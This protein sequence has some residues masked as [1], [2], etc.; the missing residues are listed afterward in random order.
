MSTLIP[1]RA[2]NII[3]AIDHMLSKAVARVTVHVINCV[4]I[5]Y[6]SKSIN[7]LQAVSCFYQ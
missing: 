7:T 3:Q 4:A 6:E 1:K 5:V 2:R